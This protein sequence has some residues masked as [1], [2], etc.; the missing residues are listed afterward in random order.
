VIALKRKI[1]Q[2]QGL[3]PTSYF[4]TLMQNLAKTKNIKKDLLRHNHF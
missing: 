1:G 4:D 3:V 2:A